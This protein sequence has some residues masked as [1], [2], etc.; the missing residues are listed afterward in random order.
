VWNALHPSRIEELRKARFARHPEL[1]NQE[2]DRVK[3]WYRKNLAKAKAYHS[4]FYLKN[5]IKIKGRTK[6]WRVKNPEKRAEMEK[7]RSARKRGASACDFTS[8]Q[9]EAMKK[10]SGYRCVYCGGRPARLTQDH[11]IPLSKGGSHT[12]SNIVPACQPCNSRKSAGP[13]PPRIVF[14]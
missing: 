13:A 10:A 5:K 4:G 7:R 9:W 14:A 6:A 11:T 1:R 8:S 12:A 2:R 3:V